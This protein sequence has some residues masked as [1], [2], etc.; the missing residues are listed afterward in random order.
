MRNFKIPF[1]FFLLT[2]VSSVSALAQ[3]PNISTPLPNTTSPPAPADTPAG[4]PLSSNDI[5]DKVVER[6]HFFM[7]QMRHLHPLVETYIQ[8]LKGEEG[9]IVPASDQYFLG[10]IDMSNGAED[11]VFKSQSGFGRRFVSKLTSIYGMKFLPL[12]FAQMVVLDENF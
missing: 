5:I 8:N 4:R 9:K 6:E 2:M 12:G 7:A 11:R 1:L 3:D 10:R